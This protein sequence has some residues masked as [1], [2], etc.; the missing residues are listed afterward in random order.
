MS[1]HPVHDRLIYTALQT[2]TQQT[3]TMH[4]QNIALL[5][6]ATAVS[7]VTTN[8]QSCIPYYV[9]AYTNAQI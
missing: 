9:T 5:Y 7:L 3:G 1:Y 8:V 6:C 4:K 2:T